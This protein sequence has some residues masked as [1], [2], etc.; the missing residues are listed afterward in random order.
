MVVSLDPFDLNLTLLTS[1][2]F[3][4]DKSQDVTRPGS[5]KHDI[6]NSGKFGSF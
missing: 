3:N 4:L 6:I 1:T 5:D 2:F